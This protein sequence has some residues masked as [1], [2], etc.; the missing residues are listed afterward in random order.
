MARGDRFLFISDLQIPFEAPKALEVCR[1]VQRHYGIPKEHVYCVGDEVDCYHA[2]RYPKSPD[3][4]LT[5]TQE[6]A[7]ARDR[8]KAWYAAFPVM[9]L[10]TSNHGKRWYDRAAEA[11]I[12]KA[13]LPD[14]NAIWQAPTGWR[15][16][17]YWRICAKRP[18]AV[19]HGLGYGAQAALNQSALDY[20]MATVFGHH[21]SAAGIKHLATRT[22][23]L[24]AMNSGCLINIK[25]VAFGYE[26]DNRLK[27]VL[28]LGVAV[29]GGL[30]PI[31]VPYE[32]F[33]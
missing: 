22:Q 7:L 31:L 8:L 17:K 9:Q 20:G 27:P 23:R 6:L 16:A 11:G 29:D 5:P 18:M 10:A 26:E 14:Y 12:P 19:F 1:K 21:H 25:S 15:W 33:L 30:T 32:A 28:S 13:L 4:D 24:W 2:S 3:I